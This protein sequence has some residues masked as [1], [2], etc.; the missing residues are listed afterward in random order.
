MAVGREAAATSQA[1]E[2]GRT[3]P[4]PMGPPS[5]NELSRHLQIPPLQASY[6]YR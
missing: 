5:F 2:L 6:R 1:T 3:A 4:M